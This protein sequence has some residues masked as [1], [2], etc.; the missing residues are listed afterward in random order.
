MP[1]PDPVPQLSEFD[2]SREYIHEMVG[3]VMIHAGLVQTYAEIRDDIG[4]RYAMRRLVAYVKAATGACND[5]E[6]LKKSM[7]DKSDA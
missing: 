4:M 5:M 6:K 2:Q 1:T 7:G 3:M